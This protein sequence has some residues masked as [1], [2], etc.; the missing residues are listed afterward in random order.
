MAVNTDFSTPSSRPRGGPPK[1]KWR[2]FL[3][4]P[5]FQ[6][7]YVSMVVGVTV[8]VAGVLGSVAYRYSMGQTQL[9][10]VMQMERRA[11][12]DPNFVKYLEQEAEKADRTVLIGILIGIFCL[13]LALG[14]TGIIV[15]HKLV[16]PAYKIKSL[17][18]EVRDG[19]LK[20][21]GSLRKGDELHDVFV[22]FEQM[23][24]SLRAAQ[25]KEVEQ[26]EA[27]LARARASGVPEEALQEIVE[28][29]DRMRRAL[30]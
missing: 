4:D 17:L 19:H 22:A 27:A 26:L 20:V 10:T 18:K 7:K 11:D 5:R 6:M 2:N 15:T 14:F 16:G 1:R 9:M 13:A 25:I 21:E 29:N 24:R 8:L 23:V 12:L 28:V 30:E 3:L